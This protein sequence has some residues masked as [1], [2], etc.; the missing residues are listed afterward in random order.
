MAGNLHGAY[1]VRHRNGR[2]AE[3][4]RY[5]DGL[6]HGVS[7]DWDENGRLL[8]S[9]TMVNGSG[10]QQYRHN[11][12]RLKMEISSRNGKFHGRCRDWLRDGT[13]IRENYLINNQNVTRAAYLKAA[14]KNPNWPQ[15]EK[16]PAGKVARPGPALE[17]KKHDLFIQSVFE[18]P[19]HAE[20]RA[21]LKAERRPQSRSLAKFATTKAAL[22]FVEQ[23]YRRAPLPSSSPRFLPVSKK[24]LCRLAAHSVAAS[25]IKTEFFAE[26]LSGVLSKARRGG[27]AGIR[28]GRIPPV[29]D[30]SWL[31]TDT[32]ANC[33]SMVWLN[34]A[35]QGSAVGMPSGLHRNTLVQVIQRRPKAAPKPATGRW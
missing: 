3:E 18:S 27:S 4:L 2:L 11:N 35:C 12:G 10:L 33:R 30:A 7:R 16:E 5:R 1:R 23:L 13:L 15:Y 19:N 14:R 32:G 31:V 34:C 25:E 22:K 6:M 21:W 28:P 26:N 9:F 17:R 8:G 29:A 20:A 24:T